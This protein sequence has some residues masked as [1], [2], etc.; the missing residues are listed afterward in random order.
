[1]IRK[2]VSYDIRVWSIRRYKGKRGTTYTVLMA[3]S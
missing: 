1:M 2:E 3:L